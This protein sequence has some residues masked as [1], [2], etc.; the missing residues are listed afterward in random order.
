MGLE[1]AVPTNFQS[2]FRVRVRPI[3]RYLARFIDMAIGSI[4]IGF[5]LSSF[6]PATAGI[7]EQIRV[8]LLMF[9]WIFVEAYLLATWGNTPGKWLMRLSITDSNGNKPTFKAALRRSFKVWAI[10]L[11]AGIPVLNYIASAVAYKQ[12][13]KSGVTYWDQEEK[14]IVCHDKIGRS[15]ITCLI[16]LSMVLLLFLNFFAQ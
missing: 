3:I 13:V 11:G 10:G 9:I 6:I 2:A 5:V 8:M 1:A 12:L 14:L 4:I 16:I 15:R 7:P